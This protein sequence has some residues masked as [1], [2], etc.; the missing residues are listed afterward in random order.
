MLPLGR[1]RQVFVPK[2]E[3]A[4]IGQVIALATPSDKVDILWQ[5]QVKGSKVY[6]CA[7]CLTAKKQI[8]GKAGQESDL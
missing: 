3:G 2:S 8:T 1:G 6:P 7:L 4:L 5:V